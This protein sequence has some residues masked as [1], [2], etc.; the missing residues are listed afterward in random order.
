M[1]ASL[2]EHDLATAEM[3]ALVVMDWHRQP[4]RMPK[5]PEI[6]HKIDVLRMRVGDEILFA[7]ALAP[8]PKAERIKKVQD[9]LNRYALTGG[10]LRNSGEAALKRIE[11]S[12]EYEQPVEQVASKSRRGCLLR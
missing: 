9:F 4:D 2:K 5:S 12:E 6:K 10:A 8:W 11:L 3:H 7:W 1:L